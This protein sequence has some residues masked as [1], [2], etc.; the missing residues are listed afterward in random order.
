MKMKI[1]ISPNIKEVL[2]D[3]LNFLF[4]LLKILYYICEGVYRLFV[5]KKKKCVTGEI[6]LVTGAGQGIGR[7]LAIGYASLGATVV[8]WDIN[9]ET[10]ERTMNEIKR[11][12]NS[13][14]YAYRCDISD[15]NEIFE[16]AE[17]M[18]KEIGDV[19]ILVNNAAIAPLA[20]FEDYSADEISSVMNVNLIAH[21]WMM[22]VFLPSMVEKNHGHVVAISSIL[23]LCGG[24]FG[25]LYCPTKSA[26]R[27]LME[28][29][30]EELRVNTKGKSSVKFTTILPGLVTTDMTRNLRLRFPR[31]VGLYSPREA[32]SLI[33]DAQRRDIIEK[34]FPSYCRPILIIIRLLPD[35][36][37]MCI[38]D[39]LE[40][41]VIDN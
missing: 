16:T 7:E 6:V 24:Q 30:R 25:T 28:C 31:L 23:A 11:M 29:I 32:A 36:V 35:K 8:C 5:P 1:K 10:N 14:V 2:S 40:I 27:A 9:K 22:K 41:N 18:R 19:T 34:L 4:L 20:T 12:G 3:I 38:A 37:Q 17:K 15:R 33:I 39:W 26:V 21:Y 13:S